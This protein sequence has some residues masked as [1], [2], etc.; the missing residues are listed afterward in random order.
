MS[1]LDEAIRE[2]LMEGQESLVQL[3]K[4][5]L[6]AESLEPTPESLT[7]AFRLLHSLK[8]AAGFLNF[9]TLESVTHAAES[10]LAKLRSGEL[11]FSPGIGDL[12]LRVIDTL[13]EI[14]RAIADG[15]GDNPKPMETGELVRLLANPVAVA[16][17]NSGPT[18]VPA[19][20]VVPPQSQISAQYSVLSQQ[21]LQGNDSVVLG[22]SGPAKNEKENFKYFTFKQFYYCYNYYLT[23]FDSFIQLAPIFFFI[24]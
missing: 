4:L 10:L 19:R 22:R 3:E 8:G 2:F 24:N 23:I 7:A 5:F 14:F 16:T 13:R 15:N 20:P 12:L 11:P 6:E 21:S 9:P 1:E 18:V 17:N